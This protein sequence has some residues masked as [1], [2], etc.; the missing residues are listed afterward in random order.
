MDVFRVVWQW[1]SA[2]PTSREDLEQYALGFQ[3]SL[4]TRNG[5]LLPRVVPVLK[6]DRLC[7]ID[8]Q[9]STSRYVQTLLS[10]HDRSSELILFNTLTVVGIYSIRARNL[11]FR[12][13]LN[14]NIYHLVMTPVEVALDMSISCAVVRVCRLCWVE[15]EK[16]GD[17]RGFVANTQRVWSQLFISIHTI[18]KW[19]I[20]SGETQLIFSA[21]LVMLLAT[22]GERECVCPVFIYRSKQTSAKTRWV[23][24][25]VVHYWLHPNYRGGLLGSFRIRCECWRLLLWESHKFL[26]HHMTFTFTTR[27]HF[28]FSF[29]ISD[30]WILFLLDNDSEGGKKYL[31]TTQNHWNNF[32]HRPSSVDI[33]FVAAG[34]HI[35]IS[36]SQLLFPATL[37]FSEVVLVHKDN[38]LKSGEHRSR[39][40]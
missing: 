13:Y 17:E 15:I 30:F 33:Y 9:D 21:A 10:H 26:W 2:L 6:N 8:L 31:P 28:S 1:Y 35:L 39:W 25:I 32:L 11:R 37:W 34:N 38:H 20:W 23:S 19:N 36:Y 40:A 14:L 16:G 3:C 12:N 29:V 22:V 27:L 24:Y 18:I 7:C 5:I 4:S